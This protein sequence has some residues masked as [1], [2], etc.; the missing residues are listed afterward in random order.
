MPH[1][2]PRPPLHHRLRLSALPASLGVD[3]ARPQPGSLE[4]VPVP[5]TADD[6]ARE[7]ARLHAFLERGTTMTTQAKTSDPVATVLHNAKIGCD[8]NPVGYATH[9]GDHERDAK[10]LAE[11]G[12]VL[13]NAEGLERAMRTV[14]RDKGNIA[15]DGRW[16]LGV[17][18]EAAAILAAIQE[19]TDE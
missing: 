8:W 17:D 4:L 1:E 11:R 2:N 7:A 14:R 9:D 19:Q 12:Y 10:R 5:M 13:V 18:E 15:P 6:E 16:D 3:G